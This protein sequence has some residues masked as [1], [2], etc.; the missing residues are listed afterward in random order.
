MAK[1]G[2][3]LKTGEAEAFDFPLFKKVKLKAQRR[4]WVLAD[5]KNVRVEFQ[6]L[7]N[8]IDWDALREASTEDDVN[9]ALSAVDHP[10]ATRLFSQIS[11]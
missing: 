8:K 5:S 6:R 10:T 2:K 3:T 9:A 4:G 7:R 1:G 11:D